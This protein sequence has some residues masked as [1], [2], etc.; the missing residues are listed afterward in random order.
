MIKQVV[1]AV[2]ISNIQRRLKKK[3]NL[4]HDEKGIAIPFF[5]VTIFSL[6]LVMGLLTDLGNV[7]I[8]RH[9]LQTL[10]DAGSLAGASMSKVT[11]IYDAS[12]NVIGYNPVVDLA[13]ARNEANDYIQKNLNEITLTNPNVTINNILITSPNNKQVYVEME[14]T[15]K[16][17][18]LGGIANDH[19]IDT[20]SGKVRSMAEIKL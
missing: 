16:T 3:I 20:I 17:L 12:G 4:F 14:Y 13:A 18:L 11:G 19:S 7:L 10:A 1:T 6:V 8:T 2:F 5:V 9:K 15:V